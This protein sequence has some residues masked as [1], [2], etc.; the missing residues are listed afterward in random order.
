MFKF[1]QTFPRPNEFTA[2]VN[3]CEYI[4]LHH[5]W[6]GEWSE[7]GVI[8]WL[9]KRNDYASCHFLISTN[10]DAF[11]FGD[12]KDILWHAGES[13]WKWKKDMNKYSVGIEVIWPLMNGGFTSEEKLT[14]RKLVQHLMFALNIPKENVIRH[15]DIA[16]GR[17]IDPLDSLFDSAGSFKKWQAW[18]KPKEQK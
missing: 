15:K 7:K 1:K 9:Y 13:S 4:V 12:P 18:L 17:K 10:G 16:P 3:T 8:D 14:L 2:W 11:K 6:T 5:T